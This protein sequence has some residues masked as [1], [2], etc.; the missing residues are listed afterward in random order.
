VTVTASK[1]SHVVDLDGPTHYLDF[2]G[3]A[4]GP[5]LVAV[6]GLG[7]SACNWLALA[8]LLTARCRVL[9]LDLAGHGLTPAAGRSTSVIANRRLLDRF[10]AEVVEEPV[11]LVGNSMGGL[12]SALETAKAPDRVQGAVLVNAA[13]PRPLLSRVDPRVALQF[14][15]MAVPGL[16]E[17]VINRRRRNQSVAE[18]VDQSLRLCTVDVS[19]VPPEVVAESIASIESRTPGDFSVGDV[20]NASRSLMRMLSRPE[21]VQRLLDSITAPVLLLHGDR[22]RLVPIGAAR[23]TAREHPAWRFEVAS[24]I[25]HVPMLEAPQWTADV[26]LDWLETDAGLLT[27]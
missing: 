24:D 22:D 26:I 13:L 12:I 5:L 2:G 6:H 11:V 14:A 7:G 25:G 3:P 16:G 8:P 21:V 10:L 17:A 20:L 19:R 18:Q 23:A 15:V 1:T 27:A 4:D 9:A